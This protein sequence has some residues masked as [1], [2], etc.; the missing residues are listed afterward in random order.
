MSDTTDVTSAV[1]ADL[2]ELA[3]DLAY[4]DLTARLALVDARRAAGLSRADIARDL[5]WSK[6]KVRR[7]ERHDADPRQSH[8]RCYALAIAARTGA[9]VTR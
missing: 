8:V 7:F 3:T 4:A 5:G 6:K 2:I 1:R 9:S